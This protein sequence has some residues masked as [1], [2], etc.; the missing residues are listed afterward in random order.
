MGV[1]QIT[2][3]TLR[4]AHALYLRDKRDYSKLPPRLRPAKKFSFDLENSEVLTTYAGLLLRHLLDETHGDVAKAVGA[5][6]GSLRKPNYQ[7][8]AGVEA[9]ALYAR[10]FLERAANLD[11]VNVASS[12]LRRPSTLKRG[13]EEVVTTASPHRH[14]NL[15]SE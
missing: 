15:N 13:A 8:A 9:V 1:W 7:Y 2:R 10:D 6:N 14:P 4:R 11:G 12:W 3:D 5:Y